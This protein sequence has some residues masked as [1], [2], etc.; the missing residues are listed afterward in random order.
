MLSEQDVRQ[1]LHAGRHRALDGDE[2]ARPPGS[3]TAGVRGRR[4]VGGTPRTGLGEGGNRGRV[5][6][7]D[8]S[9]LREVDRPLGPAQRARIKSRKDVYPLLDAV[10]FG[11]VLSPGRAIAGADVR[12]LARGPDR[13]ALHPRFAPGDWLGGEVDQ[14]LPQDGGLRRRPRAPE[15]SAMRLHPP[16]DAGLWKGLR[17]QFKGR[18]DILDEICCVRRIKAI[19]DYPTYR[20]IIAGCRTAAQELHCSLIEVEQLWVG[21]ATP[22]VK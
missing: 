20:R 6:A 8:H 12:R 11:D 21:S 5:P 10:A 15:P 17:K 4:T 22:V 19:T 3:R 7:P 9:R 14:R 2:P 18:P 13:G 1:A 16:I